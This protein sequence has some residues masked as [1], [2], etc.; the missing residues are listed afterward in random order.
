MSN[1]QRGVPLLSGPPPSNNDATQAE[2]SC[3]KCNKEF[4]IFF[5]H[6][7]RCNHCGEWSI[8]PLKLCQTPNCTNAGYSYCSSCSDYQAL[9]PRNNSNT[10]YRSTQTGYDVSS[11]CAYCIEYLSSMCSLIYG[12]IVPTDVREDTVTAAGRGQ[13]RAQPLSRLRK[14]V[15]AY[16]IK[17]NGAIEKDDYIDHIISARVRVVAII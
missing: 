4:N 1:P 10:S 13:L 15:E 14:Y 12:T 2:I 8:G 3:R 6:K 7:N 17:V 5:T 9:M 16:N 11:V